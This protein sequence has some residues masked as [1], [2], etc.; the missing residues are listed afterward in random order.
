MKI[1]D[2][3]YNVLDIAKYVVY[4]S[5]LSGNPVDQL[6]LQ[7]LLYYIQAEFLVMYSEKCFNEKILAWRFGPVVEEVY[8]KYRKY[9]SMDLYPV[10]NYTIENSGIEAL[11]IELIDNVI[12]R[13]SNLSSW[14]MVQ[15]THKEEP[16][17][18]TKQSNE[19]YPELIREYHSKI[20]VSVDAC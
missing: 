17:I 16:W 13:Y 14:G 18:N 20:K 3:K 10:S 7:K 15:K 8:N 5:Y 4:K 6:K 12:E 11:H 9:S 2:G 1:V 19:I